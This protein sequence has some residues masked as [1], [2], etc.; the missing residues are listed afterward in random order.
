VAQESS[1]LPS[2]LAHL[3]LLGEDV[4]GASCRWLFLRFF[5][6]LL[7]DFRQY[8][9]LVRAAPNRDILFNPQP[10]LQMQR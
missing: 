6:R 4:A 5:T 8:Y 9:L 1:D 7:S 3:H 10:F 2:L